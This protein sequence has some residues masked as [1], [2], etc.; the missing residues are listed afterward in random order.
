MPV[1]LA[2]GE[3]TCTTHRKEYFSTILHTPALGSVTHFHH[4]ELFVIL[5]DG[6]IGYFAVWQL[7][8]RLG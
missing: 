6:S 8:S 2:A 7:I 4:Q 1:Q 5:I 3:L